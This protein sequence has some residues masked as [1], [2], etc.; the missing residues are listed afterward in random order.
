MALL[1]LGNFRFLVI[2]SFVLTFS[3]FLFLRLANNHWSRSVP[4]NI[5]SSVL[6]E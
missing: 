6:C 4:M 1:V 2:E 5:N 3:L